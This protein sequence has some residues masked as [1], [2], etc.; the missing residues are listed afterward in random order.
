MHDNNPI[1]RIVAC[2]LD[3][4]SP[5][6]SVMPRL[7]LDTAFCSPPLPAKPIYHPP[8]SIKPSLLCYHGG[9]AYSRLEAALDS[10]AARRAYCFMSDPVF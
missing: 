1:D 10:H 5:R 7:D 9:I 2:S 8:F 4:M 3:L 6:Q